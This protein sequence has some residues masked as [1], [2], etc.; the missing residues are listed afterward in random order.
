LP[1]RGG[2][3][4]ESVLKAAAD[5][6]RNLEEASLDFVCRE[7]VR[8]RLSGWLAGG[9][10][11]AVGPGRDDLRIIEDKVRDWVYDYQLVRR[12]GWAA[13]TRTMLEEDGK[14]RR[15]EHAALQTG[16]FWHKFVVLGP[17]GLFSAEAQ[18]GHDYLVAQETKMEG[19]PALV[20]DVRPKGLEASSLYG[21]AWVRQR[22][23]AVLKIEW[24]PASMKDYQ[25]I[26]DFAKSVR[27]QPR[28]KFASEYAVEK[29]GLRFPSS[30][31]VVEAYR[32]AKGIAP[33]SRTS[34]SYKDY[35]FFEVKVRTEV[36]RG[37]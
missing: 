4:P 29:N 11:K 24:E 9:K 28:I 21:R 14:P 34:V 36:K 20:I 19:E 1:V 27:A 15:E 37:G 5:Y 3:V 23:G 17:V 26:E 10:P 30:Y 35:K 6:C 13:E 12:E 2:P 16:R 22:D 32:V 33:A 7:V 18:R 8:E 31:E 25:A